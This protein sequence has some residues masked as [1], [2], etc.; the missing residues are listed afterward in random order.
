MKKLLFLTLIVAIFAC[1]LTSCGGKE[2][3]YYGAVMKY[4]TSGSLAVNIPNIG[5]CEIP[6][7]AKTVSEIDG[8]KNKNYTLEEG[9]LIRIT[10]K[11]ADELAV[12]ESYPARFS[13]GAEEIVAYS[14]N[15]SLEYEIYPGRNPICRVTCPVESMPSGAN[16]GDLIAFCYGGNTDVTEAYCYGNVYMVHGGKITVELELLN[17][18]E[19]F[20]S[21]Y[22][23]SFTMKLVK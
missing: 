7:S 8:K 18:I 14:K 4:D 1:S 21:K 15:V 20:L 3:V 6:D 11:D 9:D 5:L 13:M 19:D 10:F 23:N 17:G 12:M 2:A 16:A 22:P